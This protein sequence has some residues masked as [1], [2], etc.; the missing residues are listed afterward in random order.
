MKPIKTKDKT[1]LRALGLGGYFGGGAEGMVDVKDGKIVRIRPMQ[2]GWKYKKEDIRQWKMERNG[3]TIEP[4]WKSLPGPFSLAYK[5]RVYSPN[6][7]QF[8]MKRVDWDPNGERNTQNRGKSKYVRVSWDEAADLIAGEI[9]RV[10]KEYGYNAILMQ[11]D[12]HGE[13]KTINT[14]HGHPGVLLE[15][16]GGFTLQVRNPDS[17]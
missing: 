1:V 11:G 13:C 7:I 2:Y 14:P 5:K 12:G 4:T 3:K 16:L 9:R 15:Y 17:W 6:R 10:H 8:P